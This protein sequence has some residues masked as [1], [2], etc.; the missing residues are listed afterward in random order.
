[1]AD[2]KQRMVVIVGVD[3]DEGQAGFGVLRE[4]TFENDMQEVD[5]LFS[6]LY[7]GDARV[8]T[9]DTWPAAVQHVAECGGEIVDV[10][11]AIAY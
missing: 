4:D 9:F 7:G 11:G 1:M 2:E 10:H 5:D 8:D 3:S 6:L